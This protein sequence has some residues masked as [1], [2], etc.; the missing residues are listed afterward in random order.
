LLQHAVVAKVQILLL[1]LANQFEVCL[2]LSWLFDTGSS[3]H[4]K[5]EIKINTHIK[6]LKIT[7]PAETALLLATAQ[8]IRDQR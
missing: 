4:R 6:N 1:Q 5:A 2:W 8:E 7:C 3:V